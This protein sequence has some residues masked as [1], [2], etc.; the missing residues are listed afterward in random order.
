MARHPWRRQRTAPCSAGVSGRGNADRPAVLF[1]ALLAVLLQPALPACPAFAA[2]MPSVLMV[3]SRSCSAR[4]LMF[5]RAFTVATCSEPLSQATARCTRGSRPHRISAKLACSCIQFPGKIGE[6]ISSK[7]CLSACRPF[8]A[9][10]SEHTCDRKLLPKLAQAASLV[11]VAPLSHELE[12]RSYCLF[13]AVVVPSFG[14]CR[15]A[16]GTH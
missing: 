13:A 11:C 9:A 2:S 10:A 15:C 16:S 1:L 12:Q 5:V 7:S 3:R 6:S 14:I 4:S 8:S